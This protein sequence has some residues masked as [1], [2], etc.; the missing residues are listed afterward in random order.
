MQTRLIPTYQAR[1]DGRRAEAILRS[2]VHCGFCNAT[3]PSY[4][5][6]GN[7]LDGPRGRIYLIKQLL[8][9]QKVSEKTRVHLDR[10]LSC[11]SC[12]TTCPSGVEYHKLLDIGRAL[13][14]EHSSRPFHHKVQRKLLAFLFTRIRLFTFL[15]G[16][17]RRFRSL[18]PK[19]LSAMVPLER[20]RL[21]NEGVTAESGHRG[22]VLL[23]EGCIQDALTPD[24]NHALRLVFSKL[25]FRVESLPQTCCAAIEFHLDE[26]DKARQ[27]MRRNIDQWWGLV[28]GQ[29]RV[30]V[31]SSASGCGSFLK[32]YE[33]LL[34]GDEAYLERARQLVALVRDP[35]ELL[36]TPDIANLGELVN[37][38]VM[39]EQKVP[40]AFQSPCSLQHGQSLAG[41]VEAVLEALGVNLSTL[42][43]PHLCCGSAGTYS[44]LQPG[45]SQQLKARKLEAIKKTGAQHVVSA[46]IGCQTH[47]SAGSDYEVRHWLELVAEMLT[48]TRSVDSKV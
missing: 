19:P 48:E 34:A 24:I 5:V 32:D 23:L 4:Q 47:L 8:E 2:C 3:C 39:V 35:V 26:Q 18:L 28:Q 46:N 30:A 43:E 10:C 44:I 15:L 1:D 40:V 7:E 31:V 9:G 6:L 20:R 25:D 38:H 21:E 27:R 33:S 45:V 22:T 37:G 42:A 14:D 29:Q 17:G 12:E 41:R 11:R 16:L 36:E 13:I